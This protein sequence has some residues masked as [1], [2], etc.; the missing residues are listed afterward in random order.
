[1]TKKTTLTIAQADEVANATSDAYSFE[2]YAPGAWKAS[3][4]M[5]ARE[6]YDA[7]EIEA[8]M[9]SK[10][11][12]WAGDSS[13]KNEYGHVTSIDLKNFLNSMTNLEKEVAE[14]V[15]GTFE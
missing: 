5:L 2:R 12:R 10:W 8:I 14:L 15:L 11:T 3:C 6:G 4:R 13:E 1:M 9:R 7:R